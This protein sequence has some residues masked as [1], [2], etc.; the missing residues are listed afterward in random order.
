MKKEKQSIIDYLF[1]NPERMKDFTEQWKIAT[2]GMTRAERKD[3]AKWHDE[4][5]KEESE[6]Q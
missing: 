1:E 2:K 3:F 4:I 5:T 6:T